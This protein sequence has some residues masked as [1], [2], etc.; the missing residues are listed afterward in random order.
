MRSIYLDY[1]TTT[2]VAASVRECM[3]PFLSEFYGHPSSC[4]WYGRAA[5]EAIEDARSNVAALLSCHPSEVIFTSGGTESVNLGILGVAR[6]ITRNIPELVP[7]FITS[8]LEHTCVRQCAQ[9]LERE[10]WQVSYVGCDRHGVV[11]LKEIENAIRATTR[12]VSVIHASHRIGTVQP[13]KEIAELC[14][15]RDILL[16]TDAAQSVG[17]VDCSVENL[18]VDLLSFSGHKIYAPKGIGVLYSRLGVPIEP[19]LFGEGCE[20]GLRPGTANVPH[21]VGLGQ[22]AKLAQAGLKT[23]IDGISSLRDRF[24]RQLESMIGRVITVH[25]SE[26]HRVPG[27]LSMEMPGVSA[28]AIHRHLPEICFGPA[29]PSNGRTNGRVINPTHSAL[30]LTEQQS[31]NSL[32]ISLGWTTS[33]DELQRAVHL[34][35]A[36][37]ESL[38]N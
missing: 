23:T 11:R 2:P 8:S 3:L 29:V 15:R 24:H 12:L 9:Q 30:G 32:L 25:G 16:H 4:H 33:D 18:E 1:S 22:A 34:I 6:A 13:I 38:V 26:V 21:I 7:H 20:A 37:Y 36:A 19:I 10:G 27:I 17:K 35:A 5:Q 14:R 31:S 28:E